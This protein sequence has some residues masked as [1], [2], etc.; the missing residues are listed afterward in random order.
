MELPLVLMLGTNVS[1][2]SEYLRRARAQIQ[3]DADLSVCRYSAIYESAPW[4]GRTLRP[5]L[6][7]ALIVEWGTDPVSLLRRVLAIERK[8]GRVAR[9]SI[10]ADREI[11]IDILCY[12]SLVLETATLSIPHL[13][14]AHRRF[15]LAILQDLGLG[16][17]VDPRSGNTITALYNHCSDTGWIRLYA[18]L[19]KPETA[20]FA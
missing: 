3:A 13:R 1:P 12:G 14:L 9:A 17:C 5:F 2:R 11:D 15:V 10:W 20:R 4:G 18:P 19:D 7:Q 8:V 6:N 16:D